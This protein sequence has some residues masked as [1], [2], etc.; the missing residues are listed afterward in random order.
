VLELRPVPEEA[1]TDWVPT[2]TDRLDELRFR[3]Q[4]AD[5]QEARDKAQEFVE[6][7]HETTA[8]FEVVDGN[9]TVGHLWWGLSGESASV[10]DVRLDA[11]DRMAELLPA[12]LDLAR[13][14]GRSRIGAGGVPGDPSRMALVEL[15][16][17]VARATNMLLRL[18]GEP[19]VV[20]DPGGLELRAMT[21]EAFDE[22]YV[23]IVRDYAD[24]LH[25]AGMSRE[26]ADEQSRTQTA[27]LIPD[28]VDSPGQEFFT[29]WVGDAPVGHLWISTEKPMAFVYDI[30]V[31][32]D[33]RRKGYGEAI[34]NAGALWSRDH[35]HVALG[36]NVFAHNPGARALYEKL[37]YVVTDDYRTHDVTDAG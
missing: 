14:T 20:G 29:A 32:E 23:N 11:P 28:G 3:R 12:L 8:M 4:Y 33:Q 5:P 37:G 24:E 25:A 7:V 10:M 19:G 34:M 21:G 13:T 1:R 22:F 18:D 35:G 36:L 15:P 30:V 16:G 26:Q 6:S 17:F 9:D 27:A 31:R 2:L